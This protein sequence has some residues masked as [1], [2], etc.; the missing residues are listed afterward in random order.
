M[1]NTI[2]N[3]NDNEFELDFL[4]Y[5]KDWFYIAL[6]SVGFVFGIA[7]IT[8]S[9]MGRSSLGFFLSFLIMGIILV[10]FTANAL[11]NEWKK[12]ELH[13]KLKDSYEH[14]DLD[15]LMILVKNDS[16]EYKA[17]HALSALNTTD[18]K[19][20]LLEILFDFEDYDIRDAALTELEQ[21]DDPYVIS[22]ID[23]FLDTK[24]AKDDELYF[25][26]LL[27]HVELAP[28]G[29]GETILRQMDENE[30]LDEEQ[31]SHFLLILGLNSLES[32][33]K[34]FAE[35]FSSH[36]SLIEII[37]SEED[38][39]SVKSQETIYQMKSLVESLQK[40]NNN[41]HE[42]IGYLQQFQKEPISNEEQIKRLYV[43]LQNSNDSREIEE[44]TN[45]IRNLK[46]P[47]PPLKKKFFERE[48]VGKVILGIIG[49]VLT[50]FITL[51][52]QKIL[53]II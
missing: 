26:I 49:G 15:E 14:E 52:I 13:N 51:A 36:M 40:E 11:Y 28:G 31:R 4:V 43:K 32:N 10:A 24:D 25:E 1:K 5:E 46:E 53:G 50:L 45:S 34:H 48:E 9:I 3:Q 37:S 18:A 30:E 33:S 44:L 6:Y 38:V 7:L 47:S 22:R 2:N 41:L 42:K 21:T 16:L 17:V 12:N 29:K 20:K 27:A 35:G 39:K 19:D 8:F 23:K